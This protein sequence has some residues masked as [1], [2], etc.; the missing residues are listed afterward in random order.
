MIA[1]YVAQPALAL[2]VGVFLSS[3]EVGLWRHRGGFRHL[4]D[5]RQ[6]VQRGE[7]ARPGGG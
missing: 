6:L 1:Q 4:S 5:A 3:V 7:S 2:F